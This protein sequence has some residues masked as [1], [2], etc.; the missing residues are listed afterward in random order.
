MNATAGPFA[1][2]ELRVG[3]LTLKELLDQYGQPA[4]Q[5][6]L[7]T[8]G[9]QMRARH[10]I[11]H[12]HLP[13]DSESAVAT[14]LAAQADIHIRLRQRKGAPPEQCWHLRDSDCCSTW[15]PLDT[16]S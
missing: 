7:T 11:G 14:A 2:S 12:C 15:L 1:D 8:V 4:T 5:T 16:D 9:D 13:V 3:V 6:V 10:G